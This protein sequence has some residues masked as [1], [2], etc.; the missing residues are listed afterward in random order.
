MTS[1]NTD[2]EV[3]KVVFRKFK[4]DSEIIALFPEEPGNASYNCMSYMHNGQHSAADYS[5]IVARTL[6]A[7]S[8]EYNDLKREL[9]DMG[10]NLKVIKREP[11]RAL[12]TRRAK[13]EAV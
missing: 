12:E 10:Y 4:N 7:P 9:E 1:S 11:A 8:D 6:P 5:A 2:T 13:I 3:T